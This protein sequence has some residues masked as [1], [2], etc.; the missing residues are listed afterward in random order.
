MQETRTV[1]KQQKTLDVVSQFAS[2]WTKFK[3]TKT[4][5]VIVVDVV[6]SQVRE[7]YSKGLYSTSLYCQPIKTVLKI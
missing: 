2:D 7:R 5:V 3:Q 4:K 1:S 6:T